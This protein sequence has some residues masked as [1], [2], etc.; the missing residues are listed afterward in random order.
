MKTHLKVEL[1]ENKVLRHFPA[2]TIS[3]ET[4]EI[5]YIIDNYAEKKVTAFTNSVLG[6]V[7]LWEKESYDA[8]GQWTDDNVK[9]RLLEIIAEQN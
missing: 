3:A 7:I 4:I 6:A 2:R 8:I 9:S 5:S 1:G